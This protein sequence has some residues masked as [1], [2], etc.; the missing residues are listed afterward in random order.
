MPAGFQAQEAVL[1]AL[2]RTPWRHAV[3][4][5]VHAG[6][7]AVR[8]RLPAGLATLTPLPDEEGWTRVEIR[9]EQLDWVPGVLAALDADLVVEGPDELRHR[10]LVLAQRLFTASRKLSSP[11]DDLVGQSLD[12]NVPAS[13]A[14]NPNP[15]RP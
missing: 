12:P 13:P 3:S 9:A 15:N 4:V 6:V 14:P 8:S 7:D 2:A 1:A 10:V 5:R 11:S